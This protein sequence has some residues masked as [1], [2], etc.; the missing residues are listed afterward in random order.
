[1]A[2]LSSTDGRRPIRRSSALMVSMPIS[3]STP[4]NPQAVA[5]CRGENPAS[6][7]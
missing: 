3:T 5:A 2:K 1:M 6:I 7:R 4:L